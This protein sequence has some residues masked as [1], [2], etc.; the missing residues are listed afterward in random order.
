MSCELPLNSSTRNTFA[1][2]YIQESHN[3]ILRYQTEG[4][5]HTT[6]PHYSKTFFFDR[7]TDDAILKFCVNDLSIDR[8]IGFTICTIAEIKESPNGKLQKSLEDGHGNNNVGMITLEMSTFD[9]NAPS[10]LHQSLLQLINYTPLLIMDCHRGFMFKTQSR[11]VHLT[12]QLWDVNFSVSFPLAYTNF[13]LV[14]KDIILNSYEEFHT[15]DPIYDPVITSMLKHHQASL[16]NLLEAKKHMEHYSGPFHKKSVQRKERFWEYMPINLQQYCIGVSSVNHIEHN[17]FITTVGAF[18]SHALGYKYSLHSALVTAHRNSLHSSKHDNI[19]NL[20]EKLRSLWR[21]IEIAQESINEAIALEEQDLY[22]K[23]ITI[24]IKISDL[25]EFCKDSGV[26]SGVQLM[27]QAETLNS[28]VSP[29]VRHW[30]T[31]EKDYVWDGER[32]QQKA[33]RHMSDSFKRSADDET[34]VKLAISA[35]I[36]SI[37]KRDGQV[38]KQLLKMLATLE[39]LV[40]QSRQGLMFMLLL[41]E[42]KIFNSYFAAH[43]DVEIRMN[44]CFCQALTA[45]FSTFFMSAVDAFMREDKYFFIGIHK[46]GYLIQFQSLLSTYGEESTMLEDHWIAINELSRCSIVLTPQPLGEFE[47]SGLCY[48]VN[49]SV[50]V[51]DDIWSF[52]PEELKS[53]DK[54]SIQPVLLTKGVNEQQYLADRMG[55]SVIQQTINIDGLCKLEVYMMMYKQLVTS[56]FVPCDLDEVESLITLISQQIRSNSKDISMLANV[57]KLV[58]MLSGGRVTSCKSAKDRTAM[59]V[60]FD[61]VQFLQRD[62]DLASHDMDNALAAIRSHG[63]RPLNCK[64]NTGNSKYA[65]NALQLKILPKE[66]RPP[67][68]SYGGKIT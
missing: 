47:L 40:T 33:V 4:V 16:Y 22:D 65:F 50:G 24:T 28:A 38:H 52:L 10:T 44:Q 55:S 15:L 46:L 51:G 39:P 8:I 19:S 1:S 20:I 41:E 64:R 62:H 66:L 23:A 26:V 11:Q 27:A 68:G 45:L 21:D 32:Y 67:S 30:S 6:T 31:P 18:A 13:L 5:S 35:F 25:T 9:V 54:I 12:E 63:V 43:P 59:S 34:Q 60:T 56:G 48:S 58:R 3:W 57:D 42:N 36:R 7:I 14:K 29:R 17:Y 61:A 49:I 37:E 2:V 53:G